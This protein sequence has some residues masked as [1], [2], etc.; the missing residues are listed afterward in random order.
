[1][2]YIVGKFI[3]DI[4]SNSDNGYMVGLL[5]VSDSDEE[6]YI[7]KVITFT[8]IFDELKYKTNYKMEGNFVS[9][10]KYGKQ[11]QVESYEM[12]LPTEK[13][14]LVEFLSSS[15]FPIGDKMALNIVNKLGNDTINII[16]RDDGCLSDIPR[17]S[18]EKARIIR[19]K[20][21]EYQSTSHI[22]IELNKMGFSTKNAIA[23]MKK[24][25]DA[26]ID[27]V[28]DDI[29]KIMDDIEITFDEI[30]KIARNIGYL[31]NDERRLLAL[32]INMMKIL[33]FNSGDTY[34]YFDE[35][36]EYMVKHTD[37][38]S[39]ELFEYILLKLEK[40]E[41]IVKDRDRYYLRELYES[42]KYISDRLYRLN[43]LERR[44]LPKLDKKINQLELVSGITYDESQREAI[45][46]ALNNNLTIITG[47]PG[48]GKTTII[49]CIV[50]LLIEINGLKMDRLALLAP[51]GRAARKLMDTTGVPAY[52]IHKYLK[53]DKEKNEFSVNEYCPNKEE[54]IIIDEASMIDSVL[55]SSL[56]KG[57]TLNAKVIL[58]GDYYQLPSVSQGQVLKDLIDSNCLDTVKLNCLYRQSEDS[59]ITTLAHE[60]KN[61]EISENFLS[62]YDDYNFL[63][64]SNDKILGSVVDVVKK[65]LDKGYSDKDIQILAPMYKSINGIDSLNKILQE[66]MNPK[67][68]SKNE[69]TSGEIIYREGDKILQLV[70]DSDNSI[71]NGDIGYIESIMPTNKT[72][73][74]K[75]EI[76]INF[77]GNRV[78]YTPKD[79]KNITHGY[80]ISVHKS[81]GGEFKMVIMPMSSSFRRMLY[82]KL[83]YT[84]VT[85]AK[86]KLI[87]VGD[88]QAF[89]YGIRND[90][91]ENRKTGLKEMIENKY[92][93]S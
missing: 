49:R 87:L 46:K 85:R 82:N 45:Y 24:Y 31:L 75:N 90:Y 73:S 72:K 30:D 29:Y 76:V 10:N 91:V 79:F 47:G 37:Q 59:Y 86:E 80:A 54:Y 51:T 68:A 11:F 50:K 77:F 5:R 19:E 71:S 8:G 18:E 52:T 64:C 61:K 3:Q 53:W 56:L 88:P 66:I 41:R 26:A 92:N 89:I 55:M 83:I 57:I 1:M 2:A 14:E 81:Q 7:N 44:K 16:M 21:L 39:Y 60:I 36:Y 6:E 12:I 38:V 17:L 25:G 43:N 22:V 58:V 93:I 15:L 23:I 20:I 78:T 9:H 27:I 84:A 32:T 74:K 34:L 48:T 70:N 33:T 40:L 13:E 28:Y 69:I 62:K 63:Q 65:A 67:D 42:E 4:Y 35:M